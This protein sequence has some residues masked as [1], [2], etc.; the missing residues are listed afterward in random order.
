MQQN[1]KTNCHCQNPECQYQ[2]VVLMGALKVLQ[3]LQPGSEFKMTAKVVQD[4]KTQLA[5]M[6]VG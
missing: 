6:V 2:R 4:V 1:G 5:M 3:E